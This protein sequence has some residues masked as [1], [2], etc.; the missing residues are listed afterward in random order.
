MSELIDVKIPKE[1]AE[2]WAAN[3][4][5]ENV[6]GSEAERIKCSAEDVIILACRNAL[7][8]IQH[9]AQMDEDRLRRGNCHEG[10]MPHIKGP[11]CIGW[12]PVDV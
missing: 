11:Y 2:R 9:K 3:V 5:W 4:V 7:A 1:W 10:T 8:K 12:E 6:N